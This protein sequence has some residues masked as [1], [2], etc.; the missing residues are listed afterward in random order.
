[1][2]GDI[3]TYKIEDGVMRSMTDLERLKL[4]REAL[5]LNRPAP[6]TKREPQIRYM[7]AKV[8]CDK[9]IRDITDKT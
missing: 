3:D 6:G 9:L 7:L 2:I 4:I 5:H 8:A 1:M